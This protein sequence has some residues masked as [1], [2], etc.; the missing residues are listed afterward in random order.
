[1]VAKTVLTKAMAKGI[2]KGRLQVV[3]A[4]GSQE[5]F[6]EGGEGWPDVVLRF[7]DSRVPWEILKDAD[8]GM[9]EAFMFG[10]MVFD[11]GDI[12]GFAKLLR[13]NNRF[14]D[15]GGSLSASLSSRLLTKTRVRWQQFNNRVRARQN[16]AHHYDIGNAMYELMLDAEHMQYSCA[17]WP[18][19]DMTLAEAQ[20]AKLAHIAS[21]LALADGQEILD[22]G[23]GWG[24]MAIYLAKR[25]NVRVKGITLAEEQVALAKERAE[26]AGVADRV[27]FELKDFR[28]LAGEGARFDRIV[29]VG[30]LEHVGKAQFDPFFA[31]C[32]EVLKTDGV[33]LVHTIGRM[34]SPGQTDRFTSKYIFPGG[35]I[36]ALSETVESSEKFRLI[37]TDIET[38]RVHYAKTIE[39]WYANCVANREAIIEMFDEAFYRMWTLY[40]AGAATMFENGGMCNYQIQY[41]RDRHALPLT[42]DY[43]ADA[44]ARLLSAS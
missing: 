24:G 31:V 33:M 11:K 25:F 1:M 4:D 21:K 26:Q 19:D 14:E 3:F 18:R 43:L 13:M 42:R 32:R 38:L 8:L 35:Y 5:T 17:Y 6:G 12:M 16:A 20:E 22:I 2:T 23:C 15:T 36:P 44:E 9:G 34:G 39:R 28:D 41:V 27:T 7:T 10:R 40:L 29:S 30:M 37:M